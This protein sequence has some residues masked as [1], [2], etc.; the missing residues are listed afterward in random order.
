MKTILTRS[1]W[2]LAVLLLVP[3]CSDDAPVEVDRGVAGIGQSATPG[4]AVDARAEASRPLEAWQRELLHIA[5]EAASRFPMN[6]HWKNRGRAQD[7]VVTACFR[8]GQ[9]ELARGYGERIADWRRGT[10]L[11]D[12]A[13]YQARAGVEQGLEPVLAE[14][15]RVLEEERKKPNAQEWRGDLV[16]LKIARAWTAMGQPQ[17]AAAVSAG[18]EA[19]SAHAVDSAWASTITER[20]ARL[21]A[22]QARAEL[23]SI[24]ANFASMSLGQQAAAG[25]LLVALH[26]RF[27]A[28][29]G[30]RTEV[31]KRPLQMWD[32]LMP[33]VRFD[34]L[35][36][37]IRANVAKGATARAK[38]MLEMVR[39]IFSGHTWREEDELQ[40]RGF[41]IELT[42]LVGE[43]ERARTDVASAVA[44]YHEVRKDIVDIYRA[45][46]LR[47]L[48]SAS[49]L[50]GDR[51]GAA[52][53]L[54]LVLEEGMVNPNSRPRCDDLV[55]TCTELVMRGFEPPPASLLRIRAIANGLGEPW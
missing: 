18:I 14:A 29:A 38:E 51:D 10:S 31:E 42:A 32:T 2:T 8:L 55:D 6:P 36:K 35:G 33:S 47:P 11:A 50:L 20:V 21:D 26:D 12:Y 15:Q 46:A 49:F 34:S 28:D 4:K 7:V 39:K 41:F 5:F 44:R 52:E 24:D 19:E 43:A 16:A 1:C 13:W 9:P 3:C 48:M 45:K 53:L 40:W 54:K 22:E 30:L 37:M 23:A 17:R 27:F 25:E